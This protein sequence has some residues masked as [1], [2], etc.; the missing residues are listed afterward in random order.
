MALRGPAGVVHDIIV[1][2]E[3]REGGVGRK[4]LEAAL[5]ALAER[6]A[7]RVVLHTAAKNAT[8]QRLFEAAGFRPTMI[9]MTREA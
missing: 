7:P 8:A 3:R 1:D 2:P 4:L 9:E 6:G 5:A